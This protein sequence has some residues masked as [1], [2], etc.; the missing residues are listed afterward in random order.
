MLLRTRNHTLAKTLNLFGSIRNELLFPILSSAFFISPP[1]F[2]RGAF[3]L[4]KQYVYTPESMKAVTGFLWPLR[5]DA[6]FRPRLPEREER[7]F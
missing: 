4:R 6:G 5:K 7:G 2:A 1:Y 3:V